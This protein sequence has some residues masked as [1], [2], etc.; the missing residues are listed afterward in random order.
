MRERIGFTGILFLSFFLL[1]CNSE[2]SSGTAQGGLALS[3]DDHF[4]DE[5]YALAPLLKKHRAKSTF[6]LTCSTPLSAREISMLR[7]L[8]QEGHEI[9]YHGTIHGNAKMMLRDEGV[10]G[11]LNR[12]IQ[13]GLRY[14]RDAGFNPTSYAHPGGNHTTQADS[15]LLAQGFTVLRDVAKAERKMYGIT[16]YHI[17]PRLHPFIY[18]KPGSGPMVDALLIDSETNISRKEIRD[19][20]VKAKETGTVLMLFGHKPLHSPPKSEEYGFQVPFLQYIV[21]QADS[22]NL[23]FYTMAELPTLPD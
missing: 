8:K 1:G 11:Y 5:W 3:F 10:E 18:Y 16:L 4:I 6:F 14:L 23:R 22:L 2:K 15:I 9:G 21:E 13:P 20:L 7:A 17:P 19:A 12:E